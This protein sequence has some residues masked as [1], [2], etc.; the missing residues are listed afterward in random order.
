MNDTF[1]D[2]YGDPIIAAIAVIGSIVLAFAVDRFL[3]MR[4]ERAAMRM[5][6]TVFSREART[7]LRWVRRAVFV[8]IILIGLAIALEQMTSVRRITTGL[9]ASTAF[10]GLIVG[11]AGQTVIANLV[12]G[13]LLAITQPARIGDFVTVST[14]EK[15]TTGTVVDIALTYTQ[16][17]TGD[18]DLVVVP[19][20]SLATGRVVNHSAGDRRAPIKIS[21]ELPPDVDIGAVRR[22]LEEIEG[23]TVA[24][25]SLRVDVAEIELSASS[26]DARDRTQA[27]YELLE[28]AQD[29]LR[30]AGLLEHQTGVNDS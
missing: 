1:W 20:T 9:L 6:T 18:G 30:R 29:L 28:R 21:L 12:A 5:D 15:E 11:F 14:G 2:T 26:L 16:L 27:E 24:V 7:R 8:L 19:N 10:L 22:A 3:L 17:D 23:S 4:A 25:Q 13:M